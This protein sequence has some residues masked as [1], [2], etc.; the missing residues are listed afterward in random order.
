MPRVELV[1]DEK[2]LLLVDGRLTHISHH[3]QG[4]ITQLDS[5]S[6]GELTLTLII[7]GT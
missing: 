2:S 7:G 3:L 6:I 4:I 5:L 1:G